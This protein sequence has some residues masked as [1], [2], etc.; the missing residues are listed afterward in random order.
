MTQ[1][2]G[3]KRKEKKKLWIIKFSEIENYSCL[4]YR[5]QTA[6]FDHPSHRTCIALHP[7]ETA[8]SV[9]PNYHK[10]RYFTSTYIT[11]LRLPMAEAAAKSLGEGK[12]PK[13]VSSDHCHVSMKP[14][15]LDD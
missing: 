9:K 12:S 1:I 6:I 14:P 10:I 8:S 11:I 2:I 4:K 15:Q 7:S 5:R 3:G 13:L